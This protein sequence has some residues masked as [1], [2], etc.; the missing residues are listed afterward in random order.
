MAFAFLAISG[1]AASMPTAAAHEASG[2]PLAAAG[3]RARTLAIQKALNAAGASI[4]A[5]GFLG[6]STRAAIARF[7]TDHGLEATGRLD[8]ATL[9]A[10]NLYL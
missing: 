3:N 8:A 2:T 6:P 1:L 4:D 7:Q 10:L 9:S 5:D